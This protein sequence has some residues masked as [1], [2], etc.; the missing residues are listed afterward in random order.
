MDSINKSLGGLAG[1]AKTTGEGIV[2]S[3]QEGAQQAVD[4]V[5][6]AANKTA[7][8]AA[9]EA[10]KQAQLAADAGLREGEGCHG[11]LQQEL[12][13][14]SHSC[15]KEEPHS[16]LLRPPPPPPPPPPLALVE[17]CVQQFPACVSTS[18]LTPLLHFALLM[19]SSARLSL[20]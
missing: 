4:Q 13:P 9:K 2:Q 20:K 19:K 18:P 7:D 10:S 3:V 14:V 8:T 6:D 5:V 15:R 16:A 17:D 12:R 1:Q 11:G